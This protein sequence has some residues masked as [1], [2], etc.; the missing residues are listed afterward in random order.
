MKRTTLNH[1]G[2]SITQTLG[3]ENHSLS[4]NHR[5][6]EIVQYDYRDYDGKLFTIVRTTLDECRAVRDKWLH[7]KSQQN[8]K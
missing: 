3:E 4:V 7:E 2:V 8:E 6:Q 5:G 1:N